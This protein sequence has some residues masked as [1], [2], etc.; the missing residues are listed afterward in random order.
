MCVFEPLFVCTL[1]TY[2]NIRITTYAHVRGKEFDRRGCWQTE[3]DIK[4]NY[5]LSD[6]KR[7]GNRPK[8]QN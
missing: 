6:K 7:M 1:Y 2:I 8:E 4:F 5:H 3:N